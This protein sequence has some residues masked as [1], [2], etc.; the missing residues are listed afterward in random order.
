MRIDSH[1]HF[2]N[3]AKRD[4]YWMGGDAL[5]PI[6]QEFTP[7]DMRPL[8]RA[9]EID[10][11]VLVQTVPDVEETR[12]F[13]RTAE[14]VDFVAGVVGWAPLTDVGLPEIL[15]SL[16]EGEGGRYLCGI[17]H[18]VHDES[19]P[20]WISRP[21]VMN[22][23]RA[24]GEAGLVYDLLVKEPELAAAIRCVTENPDMQF[25]LDHV[26]KPRIAAGELEP[27]RGLITA[28]AALPNVACKISGMV[29]EADWAGW[30]K[31]DFEPYIEHVVTV[32]GPQRLMFG[33]DWPVCLLAGS[34]AQVH[35]LAAELLSG[36]DDESRAMIFG[37][38][39]Q[40]I[41]GL[42]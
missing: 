14:N 32:F 26:A 12:E 8:L 23:I 9:A 15:R 40:R 36:F 16:A 5:R 20:G 37:L 30:T 3:P 33:S 4:Y 27:W 25:V 39:A 28:L 31:A 13:L 38:N 34:Y 42:D 21:D 19:D 2:W 41:Y 10:K 35:G 29:T 18:Q 17:R 1:H 7:D 11:T 22:G 6:R 24:I